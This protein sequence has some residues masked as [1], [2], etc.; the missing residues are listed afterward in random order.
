V[1]IYIFGILKLVTEELEEI[2]YGLPFELC[3]SYSVPK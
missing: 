2:F 3:N 1:E